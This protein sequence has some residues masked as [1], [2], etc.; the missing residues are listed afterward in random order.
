M[1]AMVNYVNWNDKNKYSWI[2]RVPLISLE[3]SL[4]SVEELELNVNV[5][6]DDV[7]KYWVEKCGV[8][9]IMEK[10]KADSDIDGEKWDHEIDLH[11]PG[12]STTDDQRLESSLIRELRNMELQ[13][14]SKD[15]ANR[16]ALEEAVQRR[17]TRVR[18]LPRENPANAFLNYVNKWKED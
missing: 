6:L 18:A 7:G 10:C 9:L 2:Q 1:E 17:S 8:H 16:I 13:K 4:Q 3:E 11:A 12:S 5:S 15:L 14:R